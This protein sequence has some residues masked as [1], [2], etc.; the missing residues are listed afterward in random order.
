[1]D[2][3]TLE[4]PLPG[5]IR[6]LPCALF[7]VCSQFSWLMKRPGENSFQLE[8]GRWKMG[9]SKQHLKVRPP[10]QP[11]P[12]VTRTPPPSLWPRRVDTHTNGVPGRVCSHSP[13]VSLILCCYQYSSQ[14]PLPA[15]SN[16]S[17]SQ[18][19]FPLFLHKKGSKRFLT[20]S[21]C[22]DIAVCV[23]KWKHGRLLGLLVRNLGCFSSPLHAM[24]AF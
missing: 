4:S 13:A 5:A 15:T 24:G 23:D 18:P 8:A 21:F 10:L 20:G 1:M 6:G 11:E 14:P 19:F 17:V 3:R 22:V 7:P 9:S 16:I 12:N 2:T